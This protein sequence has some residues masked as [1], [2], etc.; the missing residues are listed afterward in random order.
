L[1]RHEEVGAMGLRVVDTKDRAVKTFET[2]YARHYA[3]EIPLP[4]GWPSEM[5]EIGEGGAE[6]YRSN[7]WQK[8]LSEHDDYKHVPKLEGGKRTVYAEPG[9]LREWGSPSRHVEVVGPMVQFEE[10]MPQHFT[11][12]GPLLGV[13]IHL[14]EEDDKGDFVLPKSDGFYEVSVARGM[15][16][17]A[18]HPKTGETFLFV[19]TPAGVHM[20]L[21]GPKLAIEKDGIAG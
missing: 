21:S 18:E 6:M 8:N 4:F 11:R 19:Y 1:V 2:F 5:Q 12:L 16:G 13:Q 10:P 20:I 14:Y 3:R 9:F 7:K 15:L 17:T